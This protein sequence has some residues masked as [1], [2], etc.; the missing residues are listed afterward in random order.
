MSVYRKSIS[1][2]STGKWPTFHKITDQV[3]QIV[4]ESGI[5]NGAVIVYS[6]HTTCSVMIQEDGLD[7]T[8]NGLDYLQQDLI[9]LLEKYIPTCRK[10]G[11]YMHPGPKNTKFSNEHG[12]DKPGCLN[13]DAHLRSAIIGRSESIVIMDGKVDLGDFAH[14]YFADFDQTRSRTRAVQVQVI[15]E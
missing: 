7:I 10:E 1:L 4:S 6:H 5:Q 8:Y 15:G 12:E 14:I 11:Q 3:Q 13:T 2:T 9:D